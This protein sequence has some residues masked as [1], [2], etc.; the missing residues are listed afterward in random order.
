[1]VECPPAATAAAATAAATAV[2]AAALRAANVSAPAARALLTALRP[3]S[4]ATSTTP[5]ATEAVWF[6]VEASIRNA[7]FDNI[8]FFV[9]DTD[10]SYFDDVNATVVAAN[11]TTWTD[12]TSAVFNS[13]AS[14]EETF[15][16]IP[17][18]TASA[19]Y[20]DK[21][22]IDSLTSL[23]TTTLHSTPEHNENHESRFTSTEPSTTEEF[24]VTEITKIL[25]SRSQSENVCYKIVCQS[26]S[27]YT[28]T[29]TFGQTTSHDVHV[30]AGRSI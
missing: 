20:W 27:T 24:M 13:T 4:S 1:V 3:A 23:L 16:S 5:A 21:A 9:N 29:T 15:Y 8:T 28:E 2:V 12:D 19:Q 6:D 10:F 26:P 25:S 7:T 18:S 30:T 14:S 22:L 17:S 11:S